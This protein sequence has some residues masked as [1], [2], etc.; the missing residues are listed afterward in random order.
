[1]SW[2]TL[3]KLS[4]S[5][6]S[7]L[8]DLPVFKFCDTSGRC[9]FLTHKESSRRNGDWEPS[10]ALEDKIVEPQPRVVSW[11]CLSLQVTRFDKTPSAAFANFVIT[12]HQRNDLFHEVR[13]SAILSAEHWQVFQI[14]WRIDARQGCATLST[15]QRLKQILF[16]SF[17][18]FLDSLSSWILLSNWS[19]HFLRI[20]NKDAKPANPSCEFR[21]VANCHPGCIQISNTEVRE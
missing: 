7:L 1:M 21:R 4:L 6:P 2:D 13:Q 9:F 20:R 16:A 10:W 8:P 17:C 19:K 3:F 14:S 18:Y 11:E 5:L 15:H 12:S